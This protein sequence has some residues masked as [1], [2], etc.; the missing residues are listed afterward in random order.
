M[1]P[2]VVVCEDEGLAVAL[3]SMLGGAGYEP[4][5][6]HSAADAQKLVD[7]SSNATVVGYCVGEQNG[8]ECI[9]DRFDG[10][11][12]KMLVATEGPVRECPLVKE[13][14]VDHYCAGD[15]A[16]VQQGINRL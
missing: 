3:E 10:Y 11:L 7:A 15:P 16:E 13:T 12:V 9:C 4:Q 8:A 5:I 2:A 14:N 6:A 1:K